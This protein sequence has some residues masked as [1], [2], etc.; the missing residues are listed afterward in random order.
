[1]PSNHEDKLLTLLN[2]PMEL[3]TTVALFEMIFYFREA[4][5]E[6]VLEEISEKAF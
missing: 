5:S 3:G 1:M 2:Q 6:D 4:L